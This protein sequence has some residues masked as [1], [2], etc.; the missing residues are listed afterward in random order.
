MVLLY[1]VLTRSEMECFGE[2]KWFGL[3]RPRL[4]R[5]LV[6]AVL[7][8]R[9]VKVLLPVFRTACSQQANP[10]A[11]SAIWPVGSVR[12]CSCGTSEGVCSEGNRLSCAFALS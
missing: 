2:R 8:W 1:G 12:S 11:I 10:T 3:I 7:S 9:D 4:L 5:E 6:T